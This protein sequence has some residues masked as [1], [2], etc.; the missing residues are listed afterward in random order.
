VF[1]WK[2]FVDSRF[3]TI[4]ALTVHYKLWRAVPSPA[5]DILSTNGNGNIEHKA[6]QPMAHVAQATTNTNTSSATKPTV[7]LLHGFGGSVFSWKRSWRGL[8]DIC[9]TI[10]AFDRPGFGL[11]T[12]LLPNSSGDYGTYR[13]DKVYYLFLP[14]Y[15]IGFLLT[16]DSLI[17]CCIRRVLFSHNQIHIQL[18][19]VFH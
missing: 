10:L 5:T 11:T 7:V 4:D 14:F 1:G 13:D 19:M 3:I 18:I 12:R 2:W 9:S 16:N 8:T 6:E 15:M 17:W